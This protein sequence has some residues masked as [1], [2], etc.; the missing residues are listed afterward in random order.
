MVPIF[1]GCGNNITSC[2]GDTITF[3]CTLES[4]SHVWN[5][6]PHETTI[7]PGTT[8]DE[9]LMG[10]TFR[11]VETGATAIVSAVTG[12][13]IPEINNT[14]IVCSD[15]LQLAGQ[16]ET[17]EGTVSVIGECLMQ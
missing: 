2:V 13:V 16:G 14:M 17:Q 5:F 8:E 3:N 9:V 10:F 6:G 7:S 4:I 12:I 1:I 11:L 15:G